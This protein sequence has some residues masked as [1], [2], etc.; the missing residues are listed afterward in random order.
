MRTTSL[1]KR[2][3]ADLGYP[4]AAGVLRA[5]RLL[6]E[7]YGASDYHAS[8]HTQTAPSWIFKLPRYGNAEVGVRM[9]KRD[10]TLYMRG[11]T[12]DAGCVVGSPFRVADLTERV[13]QTL[14]RVPEKG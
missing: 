13:I 12:R 11:R 2:T 10:T 3:L 6:E 14:L 4:V 7:R 1:D 9:N 8:G 5:I